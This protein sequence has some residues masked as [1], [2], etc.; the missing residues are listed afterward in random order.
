[1]RIN[2]RQTPINLTHIL[3]FHPNDAPVL[4]A[5]FHSSVHQLARQHYT[6]AQLQAWATVD[7]DAAQ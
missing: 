5:V 2:W 4:R 1:M 3:F 6:A 7:Y